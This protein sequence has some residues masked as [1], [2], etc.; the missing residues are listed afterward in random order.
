[1]CKEEAWEKK[2]NKRGQVIKGII[3]PINMYGLYAMDEL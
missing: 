2:K 3:G 1:M